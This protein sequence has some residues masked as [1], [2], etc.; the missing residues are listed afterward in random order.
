MMISDLP[1]DLLEEILFRVPATTCLRSTCKR[2]EALFKSQGFNKKHFG[3]A[4]KQSMLLMLRNYR[5]CPVRVDHN[6][7]PPTIEYKGALRLN[8]SHS[9]TQQVDISNVYHCD[10]LLLCTT[11]AHKLVI[12]NPCS[13]EARWIQLNTGQDWNTQFAL[14]YVNNKSCRSYKILNYS[15]RHLR[16]G[17]VRI[18]EF[19]SDTWKV[20]DVDTDSLG[21][22]LQLDGVSLKGNAYWS[23]FNETDRS[24]F[25]L[26]FDFTRERFRRLSFPTFQNFG[27]N[28]LSVVREEQLS[29]L[30]RCFG[31]SKM[32]L[33]VTNEIDTEAALLWTKSFAV[34]FHPKLRIGIPS[35]VSFLIDEENKLLVCRNECDDGSTLHLH[36]FEEDGQYNSGIRVASNSIPWCPLIVFNY[37]PSFAQIH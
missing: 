25:L 13:E 35:V 4:P 27:S 32:E 24:N 33:W 14:G 5:V 26:W 11:K 29:V 28:I 7:S 10:G 21:L 1:S 20:V 18:Y 34:N 36:I 12:W 17:E 23:A 15:K 9:N 16:A 30:H 37:V 6:V 8:D 22:I 3:K 2:W 31:A 19:S